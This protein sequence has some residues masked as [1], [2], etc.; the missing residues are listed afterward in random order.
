MDFRLGTNEDFKVYRNGVGKDIYE[1]PSTGIPASD[2]ESGVIPSIKT[3]A[4]QEIEG[5]G[6]VVFKQSFNNESWST[7]YLAVKFAETGSTF[8]TYTALITIP[9]KKYAALLVR[10]AGNAMVYDLSGAVTAAKSVIQVSGAYS[11]IKFDFSAENGSTWTGDVFVT[12]LSGSYGG[13]ITAWK[14]ITIP[15]QAANFSISKLAP[16]IFWA[17]YGT[18][19]ASEIEAAL[20]AGKEVL[21]Y[22]N[23][24]LFHLGLSDYT[25]HR[26]QFHAIDDNYLSTYKIANGT[27]SQ[28][29][30]SI[31]SVDNMRTSFQ[32]TPDNTHYP[33]E[34]LVYDSLQAAD[35][36]FLA[37]YGTTTSAQI[38]AAMAAGKSVI[39]HYGNRQYQ[40]SSYATTAAT[41]TF[42]CVYA[43][44]S[45]YLVLTRST[46]VWSNNTDNLQNT[47]YRVSS[48]GETPSN[49]KYPTE[50]LV[51]DS[52]D[53]KLNSADLVALTT[54]EID[55]IWAG[56]L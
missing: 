23:E 11:V 45:Y 47:Y 4:G 44:S 3:F 42:S 35:K 13:V 5:T 33:S 8:A 21:Y 52:L 50:K 26:H 38:D 48:W 49:S 31:Q 40:I 32:S 41:I 43:S 12:L 56:A 6:D 7:N 55:T 29:G 9:Q 27:W 54:A 37:T 28:S 46:D 19:T 34:K 25:L 24:C 16:E 30:F 53:L 22:N 1:K 18:T 15:S 51:K 39:C 17:T 20:L 2:L 10:G 14:T 36:I